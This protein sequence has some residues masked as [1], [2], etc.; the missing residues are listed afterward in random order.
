M[1]KLNDILDELIGNPFIDSIE[2]TTNKNGLKYIVMNTN[3][4]DSVNDSICLYIEDKNG[5]LIVSD[6]GYTSFNYSCFDQNNL[7]KESFKRN[8]KKSNIKLNK[9]EITTEYKDPTDICDILST[10]LMMYGYLQRIIDTAKVD[11]K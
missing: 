9:D 7:F 1:I 2:L 6:D 4:L 3:F 10:I 8:V 5:K 11:N